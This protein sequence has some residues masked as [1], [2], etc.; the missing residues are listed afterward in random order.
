MPEPRI[1][2]RAKHDLIEIWNYIA[3][4]SV[5]SADALV[6]D[7]YEVVGALVRHPNLGRRRDELAPGILSFPFGRYVIF[8]RTLRVGVEVV[9]VLHGSRD[10]PAIFRG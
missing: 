4:D 1:S 8:Y 7:F 6:D 3:D 10:I 5:A 9:R 2:R